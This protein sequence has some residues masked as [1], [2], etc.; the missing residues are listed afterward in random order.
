MNHDTFFLSEFKDPQYNTKIA[1][2]TVADRGTTKKIK[3][4][5]VK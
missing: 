4:L 3:S 1:Q 2:V 5:Q